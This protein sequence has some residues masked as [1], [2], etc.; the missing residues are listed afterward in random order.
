MSK[1]I[2]VVVR[3][4]QS[5]AMRMAVGITL[6]DDAI[7]VY[8]LDRPLE[9]SGQM[10]LYLETIE[11]MEMGLF[12]NHEANDGMTFVPTAEL[13]ERFAAYDHVIPY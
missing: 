5:E 4:R 1:K 2:A 11:V 12:T 7:D 13:A 3:D 9:A 8:V 10:D 6:M